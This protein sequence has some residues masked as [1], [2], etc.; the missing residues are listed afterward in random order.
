LLG[1]GIRVSIYFVE[2]GEENFANSL[3]PENSNE[4]GDPSKPYVIQIGKVT[5]FSKEV[6]ENIKQKYNTKYDY[7]V[8]YYSG[9]SVFDYMNGQGR[10]LRLRNASLGNMLF[11]V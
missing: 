5:D 1:R 7:T 4:Q 11:A 8:Q 3:P 10:Q 6:L 2:G 9:M